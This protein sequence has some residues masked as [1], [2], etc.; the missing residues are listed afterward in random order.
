MN[1][2]P[3]F[4]A[5]QRWLFRVAPLP[6]ESLSSVVERNAQVNAVSTRQYLI[7][8]SLRSQG[9]DLDRLDA[10]GIS[11]H[12]EAFGHGPGVLVGTTLTSMVGQTFTRMTLQGVV[13][14][15]AS[16]GIRSRRTDAVCPECLAGDV[17]VHRRLHWRAAYVCRCDLHGRDLIDQCPRCTAPVPTLSEMRPRANRVG[18]AHRTRGTLAWT[19]AGCGYFWRPLNDLRT[20]PVSTAERHVMG[21]G[22]YQSAILRAHHP[23]SGLP[24]EPAGDPPW[25]HLGCNF[26]FQFLAGVRALLVLLQSPAAGKRLREVLAERLNCDSARLELAS[27]RG[28]PMEV[29]P[30]A[31]RRLALDAMACLLEDGIDGMLATL[32][33]ARMT[34]STLLLTD[35]YVPNW[36]QAPISRHLN[37]TRYSHSA[38][39]IDAARAVA[40]RRRA[41]SPD[42]SMDEDAAAAGTIG[43]TSQPARTAGAAASMSKAAVARLLGTR[44]SK[45]LDGEFG[46]VRRRY[47]RVEAERFFTAALAAAPQVPVSRTQRQVVLRTLLIL[48]GVAVR[49]QTVEEVC[50]W[51]AEDVRGMLRVAPGAIQ[52][53][54]MVALRASETG[55]AALLLASRF[56]ARLRG[57]STR[58]AAAKLLSAHGAPGTWNCANALAGVLAP[59]ADAGGRDD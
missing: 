15:C 5:P 30:V 55:H 6:G 14:W 59:S 28:R 50:G 49:G 34:S 37:G 51:H 18:A 27:A 56:G 40:D 32:E 42:R 19:C 41:G 21:W 36:L 7:R 24:D 16:Q 48:L 13:E 52:H 39:E 9:V 8:L 20:K 31:S 23:G 35:R 45:A 54:L 46:R 25:V 12:E 3:P 58:L 26:T 33:E 43:P 2:E 57:A 44:D 11:M 47:T 53:G 4:S 1:R 10:A 29:Y 22:R 38:A 17:E